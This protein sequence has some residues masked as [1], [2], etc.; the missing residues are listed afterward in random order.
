MT[1][2]KKEFADRLA[3]NSGITKGLAFWVVGIFWETLLEFLAEGDT[4]NFYGLG[5]FDMMTVKEFKAR[6]LRTGEPCI[7]PE[8]KKVRFRPSKFLAQ[9][10]EGMF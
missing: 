8:H 9:K 6:N 5:K 4:I 2:N 10:I 7:V 3:A 1:V